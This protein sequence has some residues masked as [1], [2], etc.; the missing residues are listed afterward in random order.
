MDICI[1]GLGYVGTVAGACLARRGHRVIGVDVDGVKVEA[2][3]RGKA[4]FVEAR[5]D[6]TLAA[7]AAAGL[8]GGTTSTGEALD[9][10]DLVL[11][12]VGTPSGLR[13]KA[14]LSAV[15]GVADD[16]GAAIRRRQAKTPLHVVL[17]STV[18]PGTTRKTFIPRIEQASGRR[19][20]DGWTCTFS[21]EFLREGSAIADFDEAPQTIVGCVRPSDADAYVA[22]LGDLPAPVNL[23]SLEVAEL[24][25]YACN[26]FHALKIA[27]ANEIGAVARSLDA[28][29]RQVMDLVCRDKVLN[30]STAYMKPGNAFGGS[31]LPK[32][33]RGL[34]QIARENQVVAPL[35]GS[36][37]AA[38][39]AQI[40]RLVDAVRVHGHK[41][42]GIY[43][44]AFKD[45]TDD[46]RE[47]PMLPLVRDLLLD[48]FD[49]KVYDK[50][51]AVEALRG[52]N[53]QFVKLGIP[54]LAEITTSSPVELA[55][56]ADT[57]VLAR[58]VDMSDPDVREALR[59]K[60]IIDV[61]G[62]PEV[63][64]LG[65]YETVFW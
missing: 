64:E 53:L 49:V 7:C 28:D 26:C 42:V 3:A 58:K 13:G 27:F 38:N 1:L 50:H 60:V 35:L 45:G 41:K 8:L 10:S 65:K 47:S 36:M 57:V 62:Q 56:H 2:F 23:S 31:C 52:R 39:D 12:T 40:D 29:G 37:S 18:P 11:V 24:M 44:V 15:I 25:K 16:I 17:R 20:G 61:V 33:L 63:A 48:R 30:I 5:L 19:H 9:Q 4:T 59:G 21:P 14:D 32:D 6:E 55:E 34:L 22:L 51:V 46:L 43:G 54:N